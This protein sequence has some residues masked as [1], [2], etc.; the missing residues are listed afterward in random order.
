MKRLRE[1]NVNLVRGGRA[2]SRG[3]GRGSAIAVLA[4]VSM[5]LI[6]LSRIGHPAVKELRWTISEWMTPAMSAL[7]D[8]LAPVRAAGRTL[9]DYA[10]LRGDLERLA[11][12]NARLRATEGRN[13][14]LER[15][16]AEV[17][18]LARVV[19]AQPIPF[20]SARVVASASAAFARTVT[21]N[22]GR[23]HGVLNGFPVVNGS[24]VVGRVV[25]S[26]RTAARV[27]LLTD[28]NS[29][30]PVVIGPQGDRAILAGDGG[31]RPRLE[32]L[33]EDA[34]VAAGDEVLTSGV[35]GLYPRGLR[36]GRAVRE[37]AAL[38]V[39]PHAALDGLDFVSVL[40]YPTPL[41]DLA[42]EARAAER[43][44]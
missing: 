30:V 14:D 19:T 29:R 27:Q 10:T 6:A 37:D 40:L 8:A 28:L 16:L 39:E 33:S 41:N 15:Q 20:A 11:A 42:G 9:S 44:P 1:H 18:E 13:R 23:E 7:A 38:R 5:G 43:R 36:V 3:R 35:G 22:A 32:F 12:E 21:V 24:G 26:G 4:L 31:P 2:S 17:A 25:E 34:R